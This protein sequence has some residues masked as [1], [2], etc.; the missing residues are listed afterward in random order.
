[1]MGLYHSIVGLPSS[2]KTTFLAALWHLIDA[3][4]VNTRL[5][6]DRLVGDHTYLNKITEAWRRCEEVPRTSRA[7]ETKLTIYVHEPSSEL[8]I[9]LGFPDLSGESFEEQFAARTCSPDYVDGFSGAGGILLFVS[10][11][12]HTDLMT[13]ADLG[14]AIAGDERPEEQ[15][16]V[17]EWAPSVVPQQVQLV[18]LLQFLQRPPFARR[19]RRL[20]VIVSA[21]D[22]VLEPKPTPDEWLAREMP[23]LHQFL[24]NNP[25]S[26]WARVYGVSA[27]GG[28]VKGEKRVALARRTPSER[29]QCHGRN[30][31]PHDLT[32]PVLWISGAVSDDG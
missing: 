22:V 14:P 25:D 12:R 20:A 31:D 10:A 2:G 9:A 3:G 21:W 16:V 30:V 28:D 17:R 1:M 32:A 18:E 26:F 11:D 19:C 23:L 7:S 4:E 13:L 5:V 24:M 29:I 15:P 8:K 27:Q 6:L